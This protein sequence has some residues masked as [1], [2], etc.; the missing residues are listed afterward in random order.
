MSYRVGTWQVEDQIDLTATPASAGERVMVCC[1]QVAMT[2]NYFAWVFVGPGSFTGI[3]AEAIAADG[4]C[5]GHATAGAVG[6][7][8]SACLLPG[9]HSVAAISSATDT[10]TFYAEHRMYADDLV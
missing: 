8:A 1:P 6:T 9:V 5:Y 3:A 7:T 10:G 2:D 4:L